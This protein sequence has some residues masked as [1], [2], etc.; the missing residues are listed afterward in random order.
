MGLLGLSDNVQEYLG[1]RPGAKLTL[2]RHQFPFSFLKLCFA[3]ALDLM[4]GVTSSVFIQLL[5]EVI[6]PP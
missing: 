6:S 1:A 3:E 5:E 2:N 4:V